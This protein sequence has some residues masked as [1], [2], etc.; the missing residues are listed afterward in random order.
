MPVKRTKDD[1]IKQANKVHN[2][3]YDYREV[4]YIN[5]RT[6]VNVICKEHGVFQIAPEK[7]LIGQSCKQCK[8]YIDLTQKS[9]IK[10]ARE[11]HKSLYDY[12]KSI[13]KSKNDK[14]EIICKHHGS[15][16]QLPYN[17][18]KGQGCPT[19][20]NLK[21]SLSQ[22]YTKEEFI[23]LANK[24]HNNRYIYDKVI[25]TNSQTKVIVTCSIHGDFKLKPYSHLNGSGC[26][27][28]AYE[29]NKIKLSLPFNTFIS[30]AQ[31]I[32][33]RKYEYDES[34]YTNYTTKTKI[35]CS[36]HG[37]FF[38]TPHSH[39]SMKAGCSKCGKIRAIDKTKITKEQV[40]ELFENIHGETFVY[41]F[42]TYVDVS[43]KM[44]IICK[45]HGVFLQKP[46]AHYAG[47]GCYKC[48][49]QE[50]ADRKK[51]SFE[52]FK[53]LSLTKHGNKYT[54]DKNT[55]VDIFT[56]TKIT[57]KKHDDFLQ[58]PRN[59]YRGSGCPKC[60]SSRGENHIRKILE[61]NNIE[62]IEQK[63][64][65]KL[66]YKKYLK[67]DFYIPKRNLVIE[68]NGIQHYHPVETFV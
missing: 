4:N 31:K 43:T 60:N 50:V 55:F 29:S 28:C 19:C 67:C 38:Q 52:K 25:Y 32:H 9:F 64:F 26:S 10:R 6:K 63:T 23:D 58:T 54:Y 16:F 46:Y 59:H 49:I 53:D 5:G 12:S 21:R 68:F 8:G 22:C 33:Q 66:K 51:I 11:K 27:K 13:I 47:Q 48:S 24:K 15:F 14:V 30:R 37:F 45:T 18:I 2:N 20:G 36:E 3:K 42:T 40:L 56:P 44:K 34:T 39:I 17:H 1:F 7:H 41:D 35:F 61:L 62:F 65:K 57:C